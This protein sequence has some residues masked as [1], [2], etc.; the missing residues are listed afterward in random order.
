MA[1][2]AISPR[3]AMK[4]FRKYPMRRNL[5]DV[6]AGEDFERLAVLQRGLL[7]HVRGKA[8][9]RRRFV[10]RKVQQVVAYVLLF[11]VLLVEVVPLAEGMGGGLVEKAED[12][13]AHLLRRLHSH[14]LRHPLEGDVLVVPSLLLLRGGRGDR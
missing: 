11:E 6:L 2:D 8:R 12:D 13:G 14:K 9:P 5:F 3:L 10:P 4:I 1:R 7:D